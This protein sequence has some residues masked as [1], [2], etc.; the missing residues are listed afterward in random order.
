MQKYP[1]DKGLRYELGNALYLTG[2][3]K[4]AVPELQQ[5]INQ[6]NVRLKALNILG[7][8]YQNRNILDL[9]IKQ[10]ELAKSESLTMDNLKKEIIYNLGLALDQAE[11]KEEALEQFKE[12]YEVDYHYRDVADRVESAYGG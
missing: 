9:A 12:I 1:N 4:D 3:Y 10:F 11:R 8:C 5:S 2:N 7:L 6:P